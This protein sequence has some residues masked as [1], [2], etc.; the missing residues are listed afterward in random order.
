MISI[1]NWA[2]ICMTFLVIIFFIGI[3]INRIKQIKEKNKDDSFG[4]VEYCKI[5]KFLEETKECK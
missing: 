1:N 5:K 3:G 2:N 4:H